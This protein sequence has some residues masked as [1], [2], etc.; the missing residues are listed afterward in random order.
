M[1]EFRMSH[2]QGFDTS[3]YPGDSVM[4]VWGDTS[5]F[6]FC[7]HYLTS[8]NHPDTTSRGTYR[9]LNQLGWGIAVLYLALPASSPHLSRTR[10]MP[11]GAEAVKWPPAPCQ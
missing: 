1:N 3:V 10:G 7:G 8:D 6:V 4:K 5:P 2:S 11:D 9:A